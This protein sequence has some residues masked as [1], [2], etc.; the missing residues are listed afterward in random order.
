MLYSIR[1]PKIEPPSANEPIVNFIFIQYYW[2]AYQI[3]SSQLLI[4]GAR[5]I[6]LMYALFNDIW[7][8]KELRLHDKNVFGKELWPQNE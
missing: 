7:A 3:E 6:M 1:Y 2:E 4:F 5:N 8:I